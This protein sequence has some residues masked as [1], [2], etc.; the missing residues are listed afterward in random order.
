[1]TGTINIQ[2]VNDVPLIILPA[3]NDG[4]FREYGPPVSLA[5]DALLTDVDNVN[6]ASMT[7]TIIEPKPGDTLLA[8]S[9]GNGNGKQKTIKTNPYDAS[10]GVLLLSG[11]APLAD[12]QD[13]LRT[14]IFKNTVANPV[15]GIRQI[16]FVTKDGSQDDSVPVM[17]Q[18]KV[19]AVPIVIP[20]PVVPEPVVPEPP[21]PDPI[22]E[23]PAPKA[24]TPKPPTPKPPTPRPPAPEPPAP[25]P[26]TPEPPTPKPPA[27]K[28]PAP[29][30]PAPE[31]PATPPSDGGGRSI[32]DDGAS[33][34]RASDDR[35]IPSIS[36]NS[37]PGVA[38]PVT[39]E[40]F[41]GSN[42]QQ[43]AVE[44][45]VTYTP[46]P[47][48][49]AGSSGDAPPKVEGFSGGSDSA[50]APPV[51]GFGD[52]E[53]NE[54]LGVSGV[55][56]LDRDEEVSNGKPKDVDI[57]PGGV[58]ENDEESRDKKERTMDLE[59]GWE[60]AASEEK[61][62]VNSEDKDPG[63]VEGKANAGQDVNTVK[64]RNAQFLAALANKKI[65]FT[66]QLKAVGYGGFHDWQ[67][68][69]MKQMIERRVPPS[70]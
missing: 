5:N 10:T 18:I 24:P 34:D 13:A 27:P 47:Q 33:D 25:K 38:Q 36:N 2:A 41:G 9:N 35:V 39:A 51:E 61:S 54:G 66:S 31:P 20:T 62:S 11:L 28:P 21:A 52:S 55:G 44:G 37:P 1:M 3:D 7:V 59:P 16:E 42:A 12:Y 45:L 67:M 4:N 15:S 60:N 50:V 58:E 56:F 22:P 30:P 46:P 23:V 49:L 19:T 17:T 40:G 26:P 32:G 65:P 14:I 68:H 57:E 48:G 53:D 70:G 43:D 64:G 6:L 8:D 29:E 63:E 69:F